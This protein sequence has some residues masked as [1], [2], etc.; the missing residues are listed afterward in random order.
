MGAEDQ[1]VVE[2]LDLSAL[3]DIWGTFDNVPL[4]LAPCSAKIKPQ[5]GQHVMNFETK[6]HAHGC[7]KEALW[8]DFT[9]SLPSVAEAHPGTLTAFP[10]Q[11]AIVTT[12]S[13][14]YKRTLKDHTF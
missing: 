4:F 1:E 6:T 7:T 3:R 14:G 2:E 11:F 8:K 9:K 13:E 12:G 5:Y 10:H